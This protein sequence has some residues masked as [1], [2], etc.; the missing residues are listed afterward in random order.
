MPEVA[1]QVQETLDSGRQV[2]V[3]VL[4]VGIHGCGAGLHVGAGDE[5][6]GAGH[7]PVQVVVRPTE[8]I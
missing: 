5:V 7:L 3:H 4:E 2:E 8:W 6:V 1:F